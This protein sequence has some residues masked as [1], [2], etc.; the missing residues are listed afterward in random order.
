MRIEIPPW[1]PASEEPKP[2]IYWLAFTRVDGSQSVKLC[3][4]GI[5]I[6]GMEWCYGDYTMRHVTPVAWRERIVDPVPDFPVRIHG[7]YSF[8][9]D[10]KTYHSDIQTL[11]GQQIIAHMCRGNTGHLCMRREGDFDLIVGR[12]DEVDIDGQEFFFVPPATY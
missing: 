12:Y 8:V 3:R 10:G 6:T 1:H 4:F 9:V 5:A 7:E 11:N 2:G